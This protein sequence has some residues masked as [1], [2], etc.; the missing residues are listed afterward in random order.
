MNDLVKKIVV[1]AVLLTTSNF[2]VFS[3]AEVD[4]RKNRIRFIALDKKMSR[5]PVEGETW[6][7]TGRWVEDIRYGRQVETMSADL[8]RP[9]GSLVVHLFSG[10]NFPGI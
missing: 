4:Q 9:F 7:I 8:V 10:P 5:P 3:G 1:D 6:I 2:W